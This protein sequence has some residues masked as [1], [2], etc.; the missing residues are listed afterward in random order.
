MKII[1]LL[2][3]IL[4]TLFTTAQN[5]D[6]LD[7]K[8]GYKDI[9]LGTDMD[10]LATALKVKK[11]TTLMITDAKYLQFGSFKISLLALIGYPKENRLANIMMSISDA[12]FLK[13]ELLVEFITSLYGSPAVN[14]KFEK[15]WIGS[16][17]K[18]HIEYSNSLLLSISLTDLM[19]KISA[20]RKNHIKEQGK[21]F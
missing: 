18:L 16:K 11:G 21:D 7:A 1:I 19:Q 8:N 10:S 9:K 6:S 15:W 17:V 2:I 12:D 20:D 4:S 5:T 13:Y 3:T 14:N